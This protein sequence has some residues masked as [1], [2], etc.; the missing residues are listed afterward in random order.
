MHHLLIHK[1]CCVLGAG[2]GLVNACKLKAKMLPCSDL[3]AGT[4][5]KN[6]IVQA[7]CKSIGFCRGDSCF[8]WFSLRLED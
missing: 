2:R 4:H 3:I 5:P 7:F 8:L 1:N 6:H